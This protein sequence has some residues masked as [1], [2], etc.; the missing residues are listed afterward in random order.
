MSLL[1]TADSDEEIA[2]VVAPA[3]AVH[4]VD[5]SSLLDTSG[6]A[7]GEVIMIARP[8]LHSLERPSPHVAPLA[9]GP[10]AAPAN[11]RGRP[12]GST[13]QAREARQ[14]LQ[15]AERA[16]LHDLSSHARHAAKRRWSQAKESRIAVPPVCDETGAEGN[17]VPMNDCDRQLVAFATGNDG[18]D[19]DH[20]FDIVK[21]TKLVWDNLAD[22]AKCGRE[23]AIF[24]N[25]SRSMSDRAGGRIESQT[26]RLETMSSSPCLLAF[27]L[28]T[29][30]ERRDHC[31]HT[32]CL[33]QPL[34]GSQRS[35]SQLD[36]QGEVRRDEQETQGRL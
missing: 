36:L 29:V 35:T 9:L 2:A 21:A 31:R 15:D 19:A 3:A 18:P 30:P 6:V 14:I 20:M 22:V 12:F 23:L 24:Q 34:P 28:Q 26:R 4:V 13:V 25:N 1:D 33:V 32:H 16:D 8:R 17:S 27:G 7:C 10:P 11:R 5:R